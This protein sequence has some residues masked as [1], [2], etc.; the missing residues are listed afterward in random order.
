MW[1]FQKAGHQVLQKLWSASNDPF[2]EH[3][4]KP[5]KKKSL[6]L[7]KLLEKPVSPKL[8]QY[9]HTALLI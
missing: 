9:L 7:E 1:A 5:K 3:E 6:K 2:R 8:F 4:N